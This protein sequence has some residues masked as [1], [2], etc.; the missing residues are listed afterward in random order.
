VDTDCPASIRLDAALLQAIARHRTGDRRGSAQALE[1]VLALAEPDGFRR[2]FTRGGQEVHEMLLAHLDSGTAYWS[3][4]T[5]L[6]TVGPDDADAGDRAQLLEPLSDR[7]LTVLRYLQSILSRAEIAAELSI[8]VNTV[9]THVRNIY[10]KLDTGR[11]R[12]AVRQARRRQ[13]L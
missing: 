4:V 12:D 6:V 9:K 3:L 8:S 2:P 10:R 5:N 1:H 7:E 11:R 13:L